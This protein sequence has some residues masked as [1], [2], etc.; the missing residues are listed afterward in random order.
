MDSWCKASGSWQSGRGERYNFAYASVACRP[1]RAPTRALQLSKMP[2]C[3]IC[4]EDRADAACLCLCTDPTCPA[5]LSTMRR[6]RSA[7]GWYR[8]GVC[9]EPYG[10]PDFIVLHLTDCLT[11]SSR[12]TA[13][14]FRLPVSL[15][16]VERVVRTIRNANE[17][18]SIHLQSNA[19]R[20]I[21]DEEAL[22]AYVSMNG[23]MGSTLVR[24]SAYMFDST[25]RDES[26][27]TR[28]S[29][30]LMRATTSLGLFSLLMMTVGAVMQAKLSSRSAAVEI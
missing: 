27:P 5:C 22:R 15:S 20:P 10:R 21:F 12:S 28:R 7:D 4:R 11:D 18:W 9:H 13:H 19:G 1:R 16:E 3:R 26:S 25:H 24:H 23:E 8:C 2:E 30:V 6:A 29:P 14:A 17:K